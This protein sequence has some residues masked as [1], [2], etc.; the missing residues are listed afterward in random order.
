MIRLPREDSP[1]KL[2]VSIQIIDEHV[3]PGRYRT[4]FPGDSSRA[5]RASRELTTEFQRLKNPKNAEKCLGAK[6]RPDLSS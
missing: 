3:S 1:E 5:R 2:N 6:S 4:A